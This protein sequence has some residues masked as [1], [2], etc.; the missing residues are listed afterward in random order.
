MGCA[1]MRFNFNYGDLIRWLGGPY[2]DAHRK[3]SDTFSTVDSLRH[4]PPP[5]GYATPDFDRFKR[6]CQEGVP[7]AGTFHSN[8]DSCAA[9]NTASLSK[10]IMAN[11]DII[12]ESLRKEEK[13]SYHI[14]FPRFLWR[15]IPGVFLSIF[16]VAW[17]YLDP[18]PRLCVNPTTPLYPGD[19]GN[20]NQYISNSGID[21]D[22]NPTIHYG[23]AFD[24]YL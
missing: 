5:K 22:R 19:K 17:R 15:F 1:L 11:A 10:A 21:E 24:R 6:A 13:L 16:R 7:L 3:W 12:N 9:R 14:L 18:K 8:Y 23:D 4:H 20:V 2:T